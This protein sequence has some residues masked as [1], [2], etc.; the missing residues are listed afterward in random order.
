M[1]EHIT[2][3]MD[4]GDRHH[5]I[6]VF[7]NKGNE[8]ASE[9]I[10]N[11]KLALQKYFQRYPAATVAVEAGT[12]SPWISRELQQLGLR[13]YVGNPR[14]LR[15][16]WDSHD[17]SDARDA[18]ILAMVC[19]VEPRLLWPVKHRNAQAYS[20]L[21]LIK[22]RE[23]L[24]QTRSKLINHVRCVVKSHGERL[25]SCSAASFAKRVAGLLPAQLSV[26]LSY[27]IETI[28]DM[29]QRIVQL[30]HKIEQLSKLRY[31]E[32]Q[33]LRQ[34]AGVGPL[35]ALAYVLTIEDPSRFN[36]SRM[37][38][39]YLGL[40]PRRDQSGA[41]DKQLRISKAGNRYLRKLLVNC[42]HYILGRFGPDCDLRRFG[43]AIAARGG[44]NAKKRATVAVAR[45]LAVLLHRLWASQQCYDPLYTTVS[46]RKA[47]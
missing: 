45:K 8:V 4:L 24:V 2:I 40:T 3:G 33:G 14:K 19:R 36:K 34:I 30:E 21:E 39:A 41:S 11:S 27:L 47:A 12:H 16:I 6:V 13:I 38:G 9:R 46:N 5:I 35:T 23:M 42:A 44:K 26:A 32:T 43:L 10:A 18:R 20:D 29:S 22:A 1:S 28:T 37:V 17:K 31:P 7:D 15:L 25:P